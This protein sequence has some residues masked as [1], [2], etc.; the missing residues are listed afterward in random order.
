MG[1]DSK[2]DRAVIAA[3]DLFMRHGF[4]RTTMG[5][6][7]KA[8]DMSRP[9]LYLLF[10]GKE[11]VFEAAVLHLNNLRMAEIRAAVDGIGGLAQRLYTACDLW[12]IEV[13]QLKSAIPDARDM[14][15]LSFPVVRVVYADFQALLA[16]LI[17]EASHPGLP[18]TPMQLARNLAFAARGLGA[19]AAD[20]SDMRAMTRLQVDLL[21]AAISSA[22]TNA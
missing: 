1:T 10:P 8:A 21:C 17:A 6:V 3:A 11:E 16:E 2:R 20:A 18:A 9:A 14:D 4:A 15:D 12:L 19:S 5:D 22:R 13:Y 7:A